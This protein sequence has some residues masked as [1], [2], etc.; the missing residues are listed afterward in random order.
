MTKND[1]TDKLKA[2]EKSGYLED[3]IPTRADNNK[4]PALKDWVNHKTL[5]SDIK[6]WKP[7]QG[8]G[9]T[10]RRAV[11]VDIDVAGSAEDAKAIQQIAMKT[12]GDAPC[13]IGKEPKR[14]LLY[15]LDDVPIKKKTLKVEKDGK[16]EKIEILGEKQQCV[17]YGI[18]PD[19]KKPYRWHN[20]EV[21]DIHIDDLIGVTNEQL[22]DFLEKSETYFLE[23]GYAS[24]PSKTSS[25]STSKTS[26][27]LTTE[28]RKPIGD[29]SLTADPELI[30]EALSCIPN[31]KDDERTEARTHDDLI[32]FAVAI[33]AGLGGEEKHYGIFH[34]WMSEW[35]DNTDKYIRRLWDS[36][37]DANVGAEFIFKKA[38][39]F[40]WINPYP[41]W[42]KDLNKDHF[43]APAGK[44]SY[45]FREIIDPAFEDRRV[46]QCHSFQGFKKLH[47]NKLIFT[48]DGQKKKSIGKGTAWAKHEGR[49]TYEKGL[50]FFPDKD[51]PADYY[52]LWR[53]WGVEP[54]Q[55][56]WERMQHHLFYVVCDGD[57]EAYDYLIGWMAY[58]VQHPDKQ[59]EVAVVIHGAKGVGK[60][61]IGHYF[62][63]MFGQ[64][65]LYINNSHHLTG[66]FNAHLRDSVF[67]VVDEAFFAGDKKGEGVL[68]SIITEEII[69]V[70]KK[71]QDLITCRNYMHIMM[72]SNL[73]WVIR[74][75][76]KDE[77]RYFV[78]CIPEERKQ[79]Q[80]YFSA[81]YAELNNGGAAAMLYDLLNHDLS[82]FNLRSIPQTQA[83]IEQKLRSLDPHVKWLYDCL[84]NAQIGTWGWEDERFS[85]PTRIAHENY[86]QHHKDH[87][88]DGKP[89][90]DAVWSKAIRSTLK[91]DNQPLIVDGGKPT[92]ENIR[93]PHT[94]FPG[95]QEAREGFERYINGEIE[96][97]EIETLD[98][99][100][101][102]LLE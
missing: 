30:R 18:H 43:V 81:L 42:V 80:D 38:E 66:N 51:A 63:K 98:I 67:V 15:R 34:G 37:H 2:L 19:T 76:A 72:F 78:L 60:N 49:R 9:L 102:D 56:S 68:K 83:L 20:G 75:T 45:V 54:K 73:D 5:P 88:Y 93:V 12:L 97:P 69:P 101:D 35:E 3:V 11:A 100:I 41:D 31:C 85:L 6:G 13:R 10:C 65:Y 57:Q 59:G 17:L 84:C 71:G 44:D 64:H 82:N 29:A 24:S 4:I 96:W 21:S 89:L 58:A 47:D 1:L 90:T 77:R 86:I 8:I 52:N 79:N 14:L 50:A 33:K 46:L 26:S 39:K 27:L 36:I 70:E 25:P 16:K 53:G 7:G 74:A 48:Q 61:T 28:N 99:S 62:H 23:K 87:S 40:G 22:D 55:G 91:E 94:S 32:P 92:F 95:L